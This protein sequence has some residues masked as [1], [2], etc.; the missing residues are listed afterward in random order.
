[1][2]NK[3]GADESRTF[4]GME[5]EYF[6]SIQQHV[7]DPMHNLFLGT[8]KRMFKYWIEKDILTKENLKL[9]DNKLRE[10]NI[11][12]DFGRLPNNISSNWG[13]FNAEQW[14]TWTL[15]YSTYVLHDSLSDKDFKI[16]HTFVTACRKL[17]SPVVSLNDTQLD[18]FLF[19]KFCRQA[20]KEYGE[21]FITPNMHMHCHLLDSVQNHGSVFAFWLFS[22]ER[23]NGMLESYNT[24]GR[25]NFKIQ[26]MREFLV[27]NNLLGRSLIRLK[28]CQLRKQ[29]LGF[30]K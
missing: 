16:W 23:F 5:F 28:D 29:C 20:E 12:R 18:D 11:S 9:I 25:E 4:T 21:L 15:V 24:N 26:L 19:L 30:A 1:M 10:F 27:T 6:D 7:I 22:F 14:K 2:Q 3:N 13:G 8:A 17:I